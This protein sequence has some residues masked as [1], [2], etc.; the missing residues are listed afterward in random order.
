MNKI[1]KSIVVIAVF[2]IAVVTAGVLAVSAGRPVYLPLSLLIV[3]LI[4]FFGFLII[5]SKANENP[6]VSEAVLRVSITISIIVLYLSVVAITAFFRNW[7]DKLEPLTEAM[8]N[9][10]N[11]IV[12]VVVAFYFTSSVYLEAKKKKE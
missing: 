1:A 11:T 12:G 8:L 4:T 5:G 2:D 3:A 10:F 7:S 9:N 6:P